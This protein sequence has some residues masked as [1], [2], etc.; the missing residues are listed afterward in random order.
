[1]CE[2]SAHGFH[3]ESTDFLEFSLQKRVYLLRKE[4]QIRGFG[5]DTGNVIMKHCAMCDD[6]L[7]TPS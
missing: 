2:F 5:T 4:Q 1:M 7:P 6:R 3:I